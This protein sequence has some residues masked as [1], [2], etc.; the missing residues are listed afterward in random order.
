M[1]KIKNF[2]TTKKIIITIIVL[3]I[4]LSFVSLWNVVSG[5]YDKQNTVILFLK[6]II[7]TKISRKVR[8]VIFVIPDL[9]ER[10]KFLS[11]QVRKYEQGLKGE[12]FNEEIVISKKN[13]EEY[14]LKE[15]Y[16]PFPRLDSR[17]GWAG[18]TNSR[19]AHY[20]TIFNDKIVVMSGDAETLFFKKSNIFKDE[21]NEIIIQNNIQNILKDNNFKL[22]GIRD[23]FIEDEKIYVSLI[24]KNS[25]GL[26]INV[27]RADINFEKFNFELFFEVKEHWEAYNVYTGGRFS[28]YKDDEILFTIGYQNV[29]KIAQDPDS[30]LGK[31]ISINKLT[32]EHRVISIGHRN[33]QGLSYIGDIDIIINSE[34]GPKG[35]D[36]INI[37]FQKENEI[38]NYGWD[39]SSYGIEYDGTDPYKKSHSEYGFIEPFKYYIPSIG[40]SQIVYIPK[41]FNLH[42]NNSLYVSS[43]RAGS[44]YVVKIN[45]QFNK[46]L[47]EDRIFFNKR[48]REIEYDKEN[49][50]FILLFEHTPSIGILKLKK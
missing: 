24:Y 40:I 1:F 26:S 23:L 31:I 49:N 22:I 36:E 37:N 46:I 12:K 33:P 21:L 9:K 14:H 29:K 28:K 25:K 6:K 43:L 47:D 42:N 4:T 5:G 15:F 30:L 2:L 35:G 10:N 41:K 39:V 13:K 34:H 20:F 27:Y 44:I 11:N 32:G 3:F 17:L 38:P 48:I 16:L 7:P 8:D 18:E 19:R 50:L 45:D